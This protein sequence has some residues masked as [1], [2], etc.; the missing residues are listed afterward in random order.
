MYLPEEDMDLMYTNEPM[1]LKNL[2]VV[3]E[4]T[5]SRREDTQNV[6][7]LSI[8]LTETRGINLLSEPKRLK[9]D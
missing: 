8:C 2:S 3:R 9:V 1:V 5:F 4:Q 6:D 7:N